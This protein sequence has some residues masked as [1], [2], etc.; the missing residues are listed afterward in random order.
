MLELFP[1]TEVA[2]QGNWMASGQVSA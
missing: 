1:R 2:Q